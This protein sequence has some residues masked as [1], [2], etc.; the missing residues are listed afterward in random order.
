MSVCNF[1]QKKFECERAVEVALLFIFAGAI[2]NTLFKTQVGA[3]VNEGGVEI[4]NKHFF[5][6]MCCVLQP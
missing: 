4:H 5:I 1:F 6:G 3:T 2:E